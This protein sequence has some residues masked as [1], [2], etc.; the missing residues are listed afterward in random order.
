VVDYFDSESVA[1]FGDHGVRP[2]MMLAANDAAGAKALI[3]RGVAADDTYPTGDGYLIRTTDSSRSVRWSE[4]SAVTST[5]NDPNVM[6]LAYLDNAD[7]SGSD[8]ISNAN[9][10]LF[11]FTGLVDVPNIDTNTYRPGAVADHLTSFGGQVPQSSQMSVVAWLEAGVTASYGTVV[12]PCNYTNKFPDPRAL[13]PH[14][15]RGN[16]VLEAYWKSVAEPGEGLFVGEPLARP[17]GYAIV[18]YADG[19]LTIVTTALDPG[20]DYALEAADS[21]AGP[22]S[23][24]LAN[25]QVPSYQPATITL[26]NATAPVYRLTEV[27]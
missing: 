5:W 6:K 9:D 12:E 26:A 1:P 21:E 2:A 17:W 8:S 18:T 7:G 3:D 22:F 27:N 13:L 4:F 15:Y 24:A 19:T 23:T 16:T 10:V 25:I 20:H 14:Y 11:Y